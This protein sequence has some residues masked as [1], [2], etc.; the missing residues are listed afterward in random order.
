MYNMIIIIACASPFVNGGKSGGKKPQIGAE[1]FNSRRQH[2]LL[3]CCKRYYCCVAKV[4]LQ[5][6]INFALFFYRS[7]F[8]MPLTYLSSLISLSFDV[9]EKLF[10]LT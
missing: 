9:G 6:R 3:Q 1:A 8:A 2:I 5:W 4:S 7:L 10:T